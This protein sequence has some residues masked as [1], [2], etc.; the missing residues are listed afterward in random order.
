MRG[1]GKGG[2]ELEGVQTKKGA[3]VWHAVISSGLWIA[4]MLRRGH[5][6]SDVERSAGGSTRNLLCWI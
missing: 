4:S 1:Q 6:C 5:D 3:E 2:G